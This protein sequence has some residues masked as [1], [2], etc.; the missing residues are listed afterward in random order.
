MNEN[1]RN[2]SIEYILA[3]GLTKPPTTRERTSEIYNKLGLRFIF[4]DTAYSIVFTAMT[5]IVILMLLMLSPDDF[6]FSAAVMAA[7]SLFFLIVLFT[8]TAERAEGLYELKQTCRLTIKQVTA[9]RVICYSLAGVVFS[10]VIAYI[11]METILEF[12]SLLSLC[13]SAL[14]I[15]AVL[16]LSV[17]RYFNGKW[18]SAIFSAIWTFVTIAIPFAIGKE[19]EAFLAGIPTI[20]SVS[21]SIVGVTI[22]TYQIRKMLMEVK[23]Y[24]TAQ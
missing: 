24:A 1:E 22:L 18:T 21:I 14:F 7:P 3:Q 8:E 4:W 23:I 17:L 19:W 6:R 10:A 13:L 2:A 5:I 20:V 9:V 15:C 12:V 16:E 11:S